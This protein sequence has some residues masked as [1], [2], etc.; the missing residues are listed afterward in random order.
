[1]TFEDRHA[2]PFPSSPNEIQ[3][4]PAKS[5]WFVGWTVAWIGGALFATNMS[6]VVV[7]AATTALGLCFGH[8]VGLHRGVIH[9]AFRMHKVT[10]RVLVW[11][12]ITCGMDG[13]LSMIRMHETRDGWQNKERCPA[14]YAYRH[15]WWT[16]FVWY[17]HM[18][19]RPQPHEWTPTLPS[20]VTGDPFYRWLERWWRWQQLPIA[21]V[22]FAFGG[23]SWVVWGVAGR[24]STSIFGH[25]LVNYF[26]HTQG[27][28]TYTM[29]AGEEGRN[30][31]WF[32]FVSMGEGWHNN[33][34]AF[35]SSARIGLERGQWDPG[36]WTIVALRAVGLVWDVKV[37]SP[38][39][40][41]P[42]AK[43]RPEPPADPGASVAIGLQSPTSAGVHRS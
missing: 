27:E 7:W 36:W 13:P 14:Y 6:A 22:L 16:D 28:L 39:T 8:S 19:R 15:A 12:A 20:T 24:V 32:G 10:E 29:L 3:Y 30:N 2:V 17:L 42:G 37:A 33:H 25:W 38:K 4:S 34:H 21:V 35:P 23:V 1:M 5:L 43:R 41:R 9:N 26:A 11:L 18:V 40:L 31:A